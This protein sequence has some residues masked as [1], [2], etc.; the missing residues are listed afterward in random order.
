MSSP[1]PGMDPY[2]EDPA[3]WGDFHDRF[4]TYLSDVLNEDLPDDYVARLNERV[5]VVDRE[6]GRI[7]ARV[8][9]VQITRDQGE[10]G[11]P[12]LGVGGGVVTLEPVT[13]PLVELDEERTTFVEIRRGPSHELV[14]IVELLSPSNK[15][16]ADHVL[17]L[18]KRQETFHQDIHLLELDF[19]LAGVRPPL[20]APL[21]AGDYYAFLSRADRRFTCDVFAWSLQDKLPTLPVPLRSPDSDVLIDLQTL[22]EMA[23][24]RGRYARILPNSGRPAAVIPEQHRAWVAE[25]AQ[26]VI[27]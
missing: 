4:L 14:T 12:A 2:L 3:F 9:D 17:Y 1:F 7:L 25:R 16:G 10:P 21:P 19:L 8:P 6:K 22:F 15:Q 20:G 23:Y 5:Q 13:L 11:A 18:I 24:T 26:S 27:R